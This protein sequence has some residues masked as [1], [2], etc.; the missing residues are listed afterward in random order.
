MGEK[1][2]RSC[3]RVLSRWHPSLLASDLRPRPRTFISLEGEGTFLPWRSQ[4][5]NTTWGAAASPPSVGSRCAVGGPSLCLGSPAAWCQLSPHVNSATCEQQ[6][7]RTILP[8]ISTRGCKPR[9]AAVALLNLFLYITCI[10]TFSTFITYSHIQHS[11]R[12]KTYMKV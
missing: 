8:E 6:R 9:L 5:R 3:R 11:L 2:R 7:A 10:H 12:K 1:T 4:F